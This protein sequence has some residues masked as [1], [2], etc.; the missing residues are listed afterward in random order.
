MA[1]RNPG[2]GSDMDALSVSIFLQDSGIPSNICELFEGELI[3]SCTRSFH[4][5]SL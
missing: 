1:T 5:A 2:K 3:V 4:F